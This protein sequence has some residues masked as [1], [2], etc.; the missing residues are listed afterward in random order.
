MLIGILF[1]NWYGYQLLSNYFEDRAGHQL[2]A[3]LDKNEYDESQLL[4]VKVPITTLSYY[5]SST[6]FERV[7]GQIEIGGVQYKYVA[8]RIFKDSLE[9]RC[10]PDFAA[11]NLKNAKNDFFRL[12]NDLS[13]KGQD[14]K[15]PHS[16]QYKSVS[17]DYCPNTMTVSLPERSL[18]LVSLPV[19]EAGADLPSLFAPTAE[20]PP[21]MGSSLA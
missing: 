11:M 14:K 18:V 2:E 16:A 19:I 12:V 10:I 4:S 7:D 8:R 17:Q 15:A 6:S 13:N 1:F 21:D 5:N 20:M 9:Y 3:S